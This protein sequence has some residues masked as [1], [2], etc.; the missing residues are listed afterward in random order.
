MS[1]PD[2]HSIT[3][4]RLCWYCLKVKHVS[5]GEP[6][7]EGSDDWDWICFSCLNHSE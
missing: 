4:D 1:E 3:D 6:V 7:E 2:G 5:E